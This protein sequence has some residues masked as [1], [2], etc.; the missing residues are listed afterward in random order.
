MND[1][2]TR[3]NQIIR[4]TISQGNK[5]DGALFKCYYKVLT[6]T[7]SPSNLILVIKVSK[8]IKKAVDRNRIKRLVR[9]SF[10][11]NKS[12]ITDITTQ[13]RKSISIYIHYKPSRIS[14]NRIPNY[15]EVASDIVMFLNS[16]NEMIK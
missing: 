5:I 8:N 15:K 11:L 16:I 1:S 13:Q 3:I 14:F 4:S 12:I 7:E 2:R 10:R 9:E 6:N